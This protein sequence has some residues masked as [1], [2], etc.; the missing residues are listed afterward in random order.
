MVYAD[1]GERSREHPGEWADSLPVPMGHRR[2]AFYSTRRR[3][4]GLRALPHR[5]RGPFLYYSRANRK[6]LP[7]AR[8]PRDIC[9]RTAPPGRGQC[10]ARHESAPRDVA[11]SGSEMRALGGLLP[12]GGSALRR[13]H[14]VLRL[15]RSFHVRGPVRGRALVVRGGR[16]VLPGIG[17]RW[18]ILGL[19]KD[20]TPE[21][22]R[23]PK[24]TP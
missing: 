24:R 19:G 20:K 11:D 12:R 2:P 3:R 21:R 8:R 4:L 16:L 7:H 5:G 6:P 14:R 23:D 13:A 1:N 17:E 15:L 18:Q 10:P 9:P 22:V